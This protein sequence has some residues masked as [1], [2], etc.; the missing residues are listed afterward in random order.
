MTLRP[1]ARVAVVGA[2]GFLGGELLRLLASHPRFEVAMV[3]AHASAGA[4]LATVKPALAGLG[5]R[6]LEPIDA[7]AIGARADLAFLAMPHGES[8][9]VADEL[10]RRG[11]DV[12]DLGSD[13]RLADPADYPRYYGKE[14]ARPQLLARAFYGLPELTGA[15]P[16]GAGRLVASPGCFATALAL[17]IVPLAARLAPA[18][19]VAVTG[20]TGSSGSG[21]A[22]SVG[23]HHS[24]RTTGLVAYKP[25]EHQ[26]LGELS[27]LVRARAGRDV[28]VDFAPHS[29]PVVRGIL[30]SIHLR[31]AELEG[32][33]LELLAS[34]YR[35]H[36]LVTVSAGPV[37][38]AEVT[39]SIRTRIGV[40]SVG[41]AVFVACAIDNL[42]KGGAGQA[43]ENANLMMG[44]PLA[45]G[46]PLVGTWP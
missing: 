12:V 43:I 38:M 41:G 16:A 46:L 34:A 29:A 9:P 8:A 11:V 35:D 1:S 37:Q 14:H 27:Q 5:R 33:A 28:A 31:A 17:A 24:L 21:A 44:W 36:P 25:L 19:R 6:V 40:T 39:G 7:D 13:L 3:C 23:V 4:E 15:P 42:I 20:L 30:L 18:A 26:H 45:L 22:P 10:S 32:D 2:S